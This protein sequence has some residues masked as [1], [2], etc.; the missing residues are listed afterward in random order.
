MNPPFLQE[1]LVR[2]GTGGTSRKLA[3]R[4]QFELSLK[5]SGELR[6]I[7]WQRGVLLNAEHVQ[8]VSFECYTRDN[9]K[10]SLDSVIIVFIGVEW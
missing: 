9:L 2:C 8:F 7:T 6:V 5:V 3:L 1:V 4:F 10:Q